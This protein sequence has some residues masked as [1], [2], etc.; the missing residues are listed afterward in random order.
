LLLSRHV[1]FGCVKE[2]LIV[3]M[4]FQQA[5]PDEQEKKCSGNDSAGD[6]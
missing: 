2:D 4:A 1:L 6:Q 3:L 5:A